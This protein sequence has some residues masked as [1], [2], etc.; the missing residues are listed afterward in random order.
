MN[1][2]HHSHQSQPQSQL[3]YSNGFYPHPIIPMSNVLVN[4]S[5]EPII[6]S[7]NPDYEMSSSST[8]SPDTQCIDQY[9]YDIYYGEYF[10]SIDVECGATGYGHFDSAPVRISMVDSAPVR[11]V[12][13]LI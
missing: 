10:V 2:N 3:Y 1:D 8:H 11:I 4:V 13:G 5:Q 9:M 6:Q 12:C 7:P